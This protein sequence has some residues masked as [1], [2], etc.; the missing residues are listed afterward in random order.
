MMLDVRKP[1]KVAIGQ[2]GMLRSLKSAFDGH[3][4]EKRS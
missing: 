4:R 3:G 2:Q 1:G